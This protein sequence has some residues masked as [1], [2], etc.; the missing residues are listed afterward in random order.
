MNI[1]FAKYSDLI[2]RFLTRQLSAQKFSDYFLENFK[3][4]TEPLNQELFLLLDELFGDADSFTTDS[5]L[6]AEDPDFYL[7]ETG[8][9]AKARDI[10]HRMKLWHDHQSALSR[11]VAQHPELPVDFISDSLASMAKPRDDARPFI[12][13][14]IQSGK[15]RG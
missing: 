3:E 12:P 10:L 6:L 9:E 8:L 4:E 2:E 7:D 1:V 5:G 13:R 14:S 15:R 11:A